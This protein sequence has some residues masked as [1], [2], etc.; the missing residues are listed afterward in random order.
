MATERDPETGRQNGNPPPNMGIG[1]RHCGASNEWQ[2]YYTRKI[3]EG[4]RRVRTCRRCN[5]R[6]TTT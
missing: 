6:T 3:P 4:Y 2:V 5:R 1:C